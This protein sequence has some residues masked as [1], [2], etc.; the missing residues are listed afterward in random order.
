MWEW[1][2]WTGLCN[3][4]ESQQVLELLKVHIC[5]CSSVGYSIQWA[6]KTYPMS[7]LTPPCQPVK[8]RGA[9]VPAF[10]PDGRLLAIVLNQRQPKVSIW[11]LSL[12][13]HIFSSFFLVCQYVE[14]WIKVWISCCWM[15]AAQVLFVSTKNF[16]SISSGLGGC[17]S[18]KME[19]PSKYIRYSIHK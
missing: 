17:G 7:R 5:L 2:E 11:P 19:M 12:F 16:V 9:L 14:L 6:T 8:S 1:G 15:Q 3:T 18:K 10:S 13:S 4:L